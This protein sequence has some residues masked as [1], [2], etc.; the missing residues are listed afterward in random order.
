MVGCVAQIKLIRYP[1]DVCTYFNTIYQMASGINDGA[2][3]EEEISR[4]QDIPSAP[5]KFGE[6]SFLLSCCC[7][8]FECVIKCESKRVSLPWF[9]SVQALHSGDG[10]LG[11]DRQCPR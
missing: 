2:L 10:C 5:V 7:F 8:Q 1:F 11:P 9:S 4:I 3:D 6:F